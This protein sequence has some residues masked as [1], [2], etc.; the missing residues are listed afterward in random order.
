MMAERERPAYPVHSLEKAIRILEALRV[1]GEPLGV[2]ELSARLGMGVSAVHRHLDTLHYHDFVEQDP[3]TLKYA[4]GVRLV[5]FGTS[6]IR[7]LGLGAGV[8][9]FLERL[10]SEVGETVNMSILH[11]G[12]ALFVEKIESDKFLR[13][14]THV[15][16]R[17]PLHCTGMGKVLLANLPPEEQ[18]AFLT[19]QSLTRYTPHTITDLSGFREHLEAIRRQGYAVDNEEYLIGVR[20]IAAPLVG[21]DGQAVAA[22]SVSGPTARLSSDRVE[23]VARQVRDTAQEIALRMDVRLLR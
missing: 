2:S 8:R 7:H 1:A 11:G 5:E 14:V 22:V 18:S 4:L 10:M 17:V 12:E 3:Q 6:V 23:S 16:A 20:C 13:T 15:G 9:P 19:P 21:R